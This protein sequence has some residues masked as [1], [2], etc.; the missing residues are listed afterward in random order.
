MKCYAPLTSLVKLVNE[1]RSQIAQNEEGLLEHARSR[2][3]DLR[4][5]LHKFYGALERGQLTLE[6][7]APRIKDLRAQIQ[8][9]ERE[10]TTLQ[11]G[12]GSLI[13]LKP[14]EVKRYVEDLQSLLEAGSFTNGRGFSAHPSVGSPSLITTTVRLGRLNM[15]CRWSRKEKGRVEDFSR[16]PKFCLWSKVAH[17]FVQ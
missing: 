10:A 7:L 3:A 15:P 13:D 6:D 5:R 9:L 14:S 1:E 16:Q 8:E 4:A 17:H 12:G 2:T 11:S